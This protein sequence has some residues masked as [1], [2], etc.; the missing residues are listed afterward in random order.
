MLASHGVRTAAN[1]CAYFVDL[2]RPGARVLDLGCGP[3]S[4]TLDLAEVVGPAGEVVGV[5]FSAEAIAV[6]QQAAVDRGDSRTRFVAADL[7]DLLLEPQSF[8]IVH[9]HQ[10]LQ[11]LPDPV[12]ALRIM[13][14]FCRPDGFIA[15]RDADYGAMAW[16][17]E[18][19]GI[20]AWHDTY[21]ATARG[22]G[23]EPHAGRR[24]RAWVRTAGLVVESA[25][26]SVWTYATPEATRW[27]GQS[28]AERVAT[29]SFADRAFRHGVRSEQLA[30]IAAD[31]RMWGDD[32]DAW[33]FLP[34]GEVVARPPAV[35]LQR[36]LTHPVVSAL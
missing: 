26:S 15:V 23:G 3:G 19:P 35:G 11:H 20:Q 28:Q 8:D 17:P 9:A 27:W 1:S 22:L 7:S 30:S 24:L 12:A 29:S 25:T 13:G 18:L 36:G 33:F 21:C 2:I 10:V 5:D 31:W 6:A 32:P 34:H 4:I 16:F 14:K